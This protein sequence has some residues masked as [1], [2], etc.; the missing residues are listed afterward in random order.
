MGSDDPRRRGDEPHPMSPTIPLLAAAAAGL[1]TVAVQ[2]H[3]R[4]IDRWL[5]AYLADTPR[6]RAPRRGEPVHLL[7]CVADHFEPKWGD[8]PLEQA[9]ARVD[10]WVGEYP[11]LFGGLCDS[12]D[13]PPRHT[14][15]Y[16]L[17]E[18]EPEHL[19]A[20]AR[21]C[22]AGFGEV[23]V[24]LHHDRDTSEGLRRRLLSDTAMLAQRHGLLARDR[25]SGTPAYGFIHGNW[26]LDNSRPDGRWCG[27]NDE[28][29]VLRETG[30]YA[31]FTLP[32]APSPTQTRT[33]N[34]IYYAV[35]DPMRPMSH[36]VGIEVGRGP[37]PDRALMLI[38]GPLLLDWSS[39]KWGLL[40]R[41]ETGCLQAS[42][43]PSPRRIDSWLKARVQVPTRPDWFFVKLH[44]HG[45]QESIADVLLGEPM[46]RLHHALAHRARSD[47]AF[48]Y[49]YVTAREMYNLA[50]AAEAGWA[51][52]VADALDFR[53]VAGDGRPAWRPGAS[54]SPTPARTLGST[55]CV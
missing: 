50:R 46:I 43:P 8:A 44:T 54:E 36:D 4:R 17:E 48:R 25:D 15:F 11:R 35:D 31:D 24:H 20:L 52:S 21:L 13:R 39:R 45:C 47:P 53:L 22:R 18:Y 29:D 51:G 3:R 34:R 19:D 49:H 5:P 32:S 1:G 27:V 6:R 30:C 26:A 42:Q 33:I 23:E 9:K 12:D 28:L 41:I 16:P 37:V 2:A 40:P 10:R 7:L 38:Q 14:F 55:G